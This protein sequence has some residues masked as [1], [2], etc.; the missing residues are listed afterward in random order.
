[1]RSTWQA[2]AEQV[3]A[4][5][6]EVMLVWSLN[7]AIYNTGKITK[8]AITLDGLGREQFDPT[9]STAK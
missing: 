2:S 7:Q 3:A 1:M 9:R 8:V 6:S 5:Q 4:D